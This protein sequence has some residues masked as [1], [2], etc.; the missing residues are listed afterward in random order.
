MVVVM[1]AAA[2][3]LA[4]ATCFFRYASLACRRLTHASRREV[5]V[6][7]QGSGV[8]VE[9]EE[10]AAPAAVVTVVASAEPTA[11]EV[12]VDSNDFA[13]EGESGSD[14]DVAFKEDDLV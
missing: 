7:E 9:E 8:D 1:L 14:E 5:V 11:A 2:V 6:V 13:E 3:L 12:K 10:M 4:F